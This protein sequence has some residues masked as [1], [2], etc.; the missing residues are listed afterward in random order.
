M[1]FQFVV[2]ASSDNVFIYLFSFKWDDYRRQLP[3]DPIFRNFHVQKISL[4]HQLWLH[5]LK[6]DLF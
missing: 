1:N 4:K 2:N 3:V 6:D 5:Y